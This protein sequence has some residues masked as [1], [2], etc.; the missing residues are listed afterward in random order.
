[1]V[2]LPEATPVTTPLL[3]TVAVLVLLLLHVP[4]DVPFVVNVI[5]D[6]A[7]TDDD[8]LIVPAL[9]AAVTEIDLVVLAVPQP[10]TV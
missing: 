5:V 3:F 9:D 10:V 4:P 2:T 8:P 6:P 7:H 1:M